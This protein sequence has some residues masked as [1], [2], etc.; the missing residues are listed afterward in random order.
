M[1][2]VVILQ[3]IVLVSRGALAVINMSKFLYSI[4]HSC[5]FVCL[6]FN[7]YVAQDEA[8]M[9]STPEG[10]G[11]QSLLLWWQRR[12]TSPTQEEEEEGPKK[13]RKSVKLGVNTRHTKI[14]QSLGA[15]K[16]QCP[17]VPPI[18]CLTT[19]RTPLFP[20]PSSP[21]VSFLHTNSF[22]EIKTPQSSEIPSTLCARSWVL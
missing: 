1:A 4:I 21:S 12:P 13:Q 19:F 9:L 10:K 3:W 2:L 20:L 7:V 17:V 11:R 5:L 16:P 15:H 18:L 8:V 22:R 14:R 6:I